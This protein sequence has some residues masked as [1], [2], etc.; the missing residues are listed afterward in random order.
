MAHRRDNRGREAGEP[1]GLPP[2]IGAHLR[3]NVLHGE[4]QRPPER[5]EEGCRDPQQPDKRPTT[6][7]RTR[8]TGSRKRPTEMCTVRKH[9]GSEKVWKEPLCQAVPP[10]P[11]A[12]E[13]QRGNGKE[14]GSSEGLPHLP[15]RPRREHERTRQELR[16]KGG[17]HQHQERREGYPDHLHQMH[18]PK[19]LQ[20]NQ[21]AHLRVLAEESKRLSG[22]T[23]YQKQQDLPEAQRRGQLNQQRETGGGSPPRGLP[24]RD[25][26]TRATPHHRYVR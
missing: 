17:D 9:I 10:H 16:T 6:G 13:S 18:C 11:Q 5:E 25:D 19:P 15:R 26:R 21:R 22:R 23:R 12:R 14:T 8:P 4:A 3:P 24:H 20:S 1:G 7:Q 2:G